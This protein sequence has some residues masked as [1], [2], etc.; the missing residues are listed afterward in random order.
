MIIHGDNPKNI[1]IPKIC[2][3]ISPNPKKSLTA[4]IKTAHKSNIKFAAKAIVKILLLRN[5]ILNREPLI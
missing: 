1:E 2:A 3:L 5:D 4:G